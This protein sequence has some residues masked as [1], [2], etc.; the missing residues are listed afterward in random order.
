MNMPIRFELQASNFWKHKKKHE[1]IRLRLPP[2]SRL[3]VSPM[4]SWVH[5]PSWCQMYATISDF[6]KAWIDQQNFSV[7]WIYLF[8]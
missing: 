2:S 1:I 3:A 7:M 5:S 4:C 8:F 6:S